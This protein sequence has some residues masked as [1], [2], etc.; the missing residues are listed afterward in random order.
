MNITKK[1]FIFSGVC[2]EEGKCIYY[3]SENLEVVG[4]N[5]VKKIVKRPLVEL[6][7]SQKVCEIEFAKRFVESELNQRVKTVHERIPDL[8]DQKRLANNA[9]D[10]SQYDKFISLVADVVIKI[11]RNEVNDL[12]LDDI[13][14]SLTVIMAVLGGGYP[15]YCCWVLKELLEHDNVEFKAYINALKGMIASCVNLEYIA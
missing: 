11:K 7:K 4:N 9:S 2:N 12:L 15:V 13:K 1:D 6:M 10:L 5:T 8:S 3:E 14:E